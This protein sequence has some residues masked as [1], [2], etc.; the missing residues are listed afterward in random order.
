M[1]V[2]GG[3]GIV[4]FGLGRSEVG[5]VAAEALREEGPGLRV[6]GDNGLSSG[7]DEFPAGECSMAE[8]ASQKS[9]TKNLNTIIM[10][11]Q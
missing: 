4:N 10:H 6:V 11:L 5:A 8:N 2:V 7:V 1:G 9:I 3:V